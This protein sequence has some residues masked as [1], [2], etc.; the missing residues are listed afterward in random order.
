[1]KF[2]IKDMAVRAGGVTGGAVLAKLVNRVTGNMNP[3]LRAGI[4]IAAGAVIPEFM[5]KNKIVEHV[6]SGVMA[7]GAAEL[8]DELMPAVSGADDVMA[9]AIGA[10]VVIDED[11]EAEVSGND[12]VMSGDFD[13]EDEVAG[14]DDEDFEE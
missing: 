7:V 1:M 5:P 10:P 8:L 9:G 6:G 12:D 4:K 11:Y 13:D 2:K 14:A 3:K